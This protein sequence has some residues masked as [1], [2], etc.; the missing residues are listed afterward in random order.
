MNSKYKGI[1]YTLL[2]AICFATGGVL[3]KVNTW[4]SLSVSGFRSIF[5]FLVFAIYMVVKKHPMRWNWQVWAG[6]VANTLMSI[7]FVMAVRL[8]TAANAIVLQFTMPIYII[9]F[10]WIFE[11]KRPQLSSLVAAGCSLVG[12][13]F[14][15]F[16]H[17]SSDGMLGNIF[18]LVSGVFYAM[19]F[20]IK[21][22]PKS[23]FESSAII[24]FAMNILIGMPFFVKETSFSA[25]NIWTG[26]LLG[27]VQI[28]LAY[29]FLNAALD[30][31]SPFAAALLSMVE[32]ILNPILVAL[33]YGEMMGGISMIGA[34]IVLISALCYNLLTKE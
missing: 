9:L 21:R 34:V 5:A 12:I 17:M 25:T 7:F 18:A 27:L 33:F 15:F 30:K 19:V 26:I 13:A 2:S 14:F 32:P 16:D 3:L 23:D 11:K 1:I 8:T 10:L 20:C 29:I 4:S 6:A 24:S 31:V 22:I 28:G